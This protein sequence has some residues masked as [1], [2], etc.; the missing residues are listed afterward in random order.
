M[1]VTLLQKHCHLRQTLRQI[2]L[3]II[4]AAR[5]HSVSNNTD[6]HKQD[7]HSSLSPQ[8]LGNLHWQWCKDQNKHSGKEETLNP[9]CVQFSDPSSFHSIHI[10][11]QRKPK[12]I[13]IF[14]IVVNLN[15][16]TNVQ[17]DIECFALLRVERG[18]GLFLTY[19]KG[20]FCMVLLCVL[21]Y[22][23]L[24]RVDKHPCYNFVYAHPSLFNLKCQFECN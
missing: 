24:E 3:T 8:G 11:L 20:P 5:V 19:S 9:I 6:S 18:W 12:C 14:I 17:L 23:A 16:S 22:S 15:A 13:S 2:L 4:A 10:S 21:V 1:K 7:F